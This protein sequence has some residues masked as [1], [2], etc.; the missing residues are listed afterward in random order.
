MSSRRISLY[1]H[2]RLGGTGGALTA[3]TV[4][5][6]E[7]STPNV[8]R[9]SSEAVSLPGNVTVSYPSSQKWLFWGIVGIVAYKVFK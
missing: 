3:P 7:A 8:E 4:R 1:E 2:Y 9:N 6:T 5:E